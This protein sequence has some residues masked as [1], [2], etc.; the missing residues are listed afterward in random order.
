[1]SRIPFLLPMAFVTWRTM[2]EWTPMLAWRN[3]NA[4]RSAAIAIPP[5][6]LIFSATGTHNV[7]WFLRSGKRSADSFRSALNDINRPIESFVSILD[8]GCGCGRVL[9]HW[10]DVRGPRF[11]GTDYNPAGPEWA[12]QNLTGVSFSVNQ[13]I[14]PL[15]YPDRKF[16]LVY[17]VSVFTHLPRAIQRTWIEELHRVIEPGGILML[18]LSGEGDFARLTEGERERFRR[19][20][21]VEIDP[22]FAG[23]NMCG[24]YHPE[25][26]V[27]S[28]WGDLFKI[29]N[30]YREGAL[31]S[32]RQDLY[33]F[34]R[35]QLVP[36]MIGDEGLCK[37]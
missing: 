6:A 7:D 17:A 14:P 34:E 32:P 24:V 35:L 3:L 9:R 28:S 37:S 11:F 19:G 27:R 33:A 15:P 13:L 5:G 8:L 2:K 26:F 25:E 30:V 21:L 20:E 12:R 4:R 18:T 36:P 22:A 23:T 10:S 16:D 31:G 29:R 1:L